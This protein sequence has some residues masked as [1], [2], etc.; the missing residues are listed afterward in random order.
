MSEY[1]NQEQNPMLNN[2]LIYTDEQMA[3]FILDGIMHKTIREIIRCK[4]ISA[5]YD[6]IIYTDTNDPDI[7]SD[8]LNNNIDA[9]D[10]LWFITNRDV[11]KTMYQATYTNILSNTFY[12]WKN[13]LKSPE[14]LN[15]LKILKAIL[16]LFDTNAE[17][18]KEVID[19]WLT[20]ENMVEL[21]DFLSELDTEIVILSKADSDLFQLLE[22]ILLT[23]IK[24][25]DGDISKIPC[26]YTA[27]IQTYLDML[28]NYI[29]PQLGRCDPMIVRAYD[30]MRQYL[31]ASG[32][33]SDVGIYF[34]IYFMF[35]NQ[36]HIEDR[37]IFRQICQIICQFPEFVRFTTDYGG[38]GLL[39][40]CCRFD[41]PD[42]LI[43]LLGKYN[44][45]PAKLCDDFTNYKILAK[46]FYAATQPEPRPLVHKSLHRAG[47]FSAYIDWFKYSG[48]EDL[49]AIDTCQWPLVAFCVN[50]N[51]PSHNPSL[52]LV[53]L[54]D[55]DCEALLMQFLWINDLTNPG[56]FQKQITDY[57]LVLLQLAQISFKLSDK[58][59]MDKECWKFDKYLRT[60]QFLNNPELV[61]NK[62]YQLNALTRGVFM[63][64]DVYKYLEQEVFAAYIYQ[65]ASDK[66]D[67]IQLGQLLVEYHPDYSVSYWEALLKSELKANALEFTMII[68]LLKTIYFK[69]QSEDQPQTSLSSLLAPP[70]ANELI[71]TLYDDIDN[72]LLSIKCESETLI[73]KFA[74]I[75]KEF[76]KS[77]TINHC[78]ILEKLIE[79]QFPRLKYQNKGFISYIQ[80]ILTY[81]INTDFEFQLSDELIIKIRAEL[82]YLAQNQLDTNNTFSHTLTYLSIVL[83]KHTTLAIAKQL[84]LDYITNILTTNESLLFANIIELILENINVELC[85]FIRDTLLDSEFCVEINTATTLGIIV[86]RPVGEKYQKI[87]NSQWRNWCANRQIPYVATDLKLLT[88][89][90][91]QEFIC[92]ITF[93]AQKIGDIIINLVGCGHKF[94]AL[95]IIEWCQTKKTCPICRAELATG[96]LS[97]AN[98][99][100]FKLV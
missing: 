17:D 58:E 72:Y 27:E 93:E 89:S 76:N 52:E 4:N 54:K 33:M 90:D 75:L 55:Y 85:Y 65:L 9:D 81:S 49:C 53:N 20:Y 47:Y 28:G 22:L 74:I 63:S 83:R 16:G 91:T 95:G 43:R 99:E 19:V 40:E 31:V 68:G 71:A 23:K 87:L 56:E 51:I 7:L 48:F 15:P 35:S 94:S 57:L 96:K 78:D 80:L 82:D 77:E 8:S 86:I 3:G 24:L 100:M 6:L 13:K 18:Y 62:L 11:I 88:D 42:E 25:V 14:T 84:I 12:D 21:F 38:V 26:F 59:V 37:E 1:E 45:N 92:P 69:N 50:N 5:L 41:L 29:M 36:F 60:R 32:S 98:C 66:F 67:L 2:Y 30:A 61:R 64:R 70:G 39:L 44:I 79:L 97:G 10:L 34:R 73:A 46:I